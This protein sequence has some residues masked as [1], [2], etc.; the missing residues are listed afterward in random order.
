MYELKRY[1]TGPLPTNTYTIKKKGESNVIIIDPGP[2]SEGL[3]EVLSE[4]GESIEAILITHGHADHVDGVSSLKKIISEK[5]G[6]N[7]RCYAPK[8]DEKTFSDPDYNSSLMIVGEKKDYKKCVDV[9]LNDNEELDMA[10]LLVRTIIT[11]GH[12]VGG[13]SF[14]FPK[15]M[16]LFSG[17][18]LFFGSVGRTDFPGGS[19]SQLVR[20]VQDKLFTLPDNTRVL[21]GHNEETTIER[22]KRENPFFSGW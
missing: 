4:K 13:A 19:M 17:D 15:E 21:P 10:G 9:W 2:A 1:L 14:Y 8:A 5:T 12:T 18:T 11:P 22:E 16:V 20:S 3:F 6:K 7:I